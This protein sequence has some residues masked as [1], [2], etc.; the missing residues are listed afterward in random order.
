M[1]A[2]RQASPR[3]TSH[4]TVGQGPP[5]PPDAPHGP[6]V[7]RSTTG[8]DQRGGLPRDLDL[9]SDQPPAQRLHL[10]STSRSRGPPIGVPSRTEERSAGPGFPDHGHVPPLRREC[11]HRSV[12]GGQLTG[13]S[14]SGPVKRHRVG[15][16]RAGLL[17]WTG[18]RRAT[19]IW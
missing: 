3:D 5:G 12:L 2:T 17:D 18:L 6:V 19:Q 14:R 10:P 1:S 4:W 15:P 9:W 13:D 11:R 7:S 8:M 16:G